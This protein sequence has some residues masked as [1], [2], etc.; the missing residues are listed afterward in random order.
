M[1]S[2]PRFFRRSPISSA[3]QIRRPTNNSGLSL[4]GLLF[5]IVVIAVIVNAF[6]VTA[7]RV[8]QNGMFPNITSGE[9]VFARLRPYGA[10]AEVSRGDIVIFKRIHRG[11]SYRFIWR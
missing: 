2:V 10:A 4:F 1:L 9:M 8:P 11:Q 5:I 6:F 3:R 7:F